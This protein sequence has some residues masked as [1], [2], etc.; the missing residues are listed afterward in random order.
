MVGY[1]V[2]G[3]AMGCVPPLSISK[4]GMCIRLLIS[5]QLVKMCGGL[6]EQEWSV[7]RARSM[8]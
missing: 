4:P 5:V 3:C 8:V 2:S 7:T 6:R 1:L